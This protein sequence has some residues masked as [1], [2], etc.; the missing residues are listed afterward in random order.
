MRRMCPHR[1]SLD[2]FANPSLVADWQRLI[3]IRDEVNRALESARQ[4]KTIGTSL[5]AQ[6]TL[7]ARG[8]SLTLLDKYRNELPMLFIASQVTVTEAPGQGDA[9]ELT[10]SRAEGVKCA[11]C[12]RIVPEV[13]SESGSEGLCSRCVEAIEANGGI[14]A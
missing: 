13:S 2:A 9:V 6:V 4:A 8:D 1:E 5:G 3:A 11:R 12:W 10:V 14:A 7:R